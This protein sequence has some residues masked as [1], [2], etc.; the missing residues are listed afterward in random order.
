MSKQSRF[1]LVTAASIALTAGIAVS[2]TAA[3]SAVA[4]GVLRPVEALIVNTDSKPV[5][6]TVVGTRMHLGV[7]L[8]DHVMLAAS[9]VA[10]DCG[11]A[12]SFQ[13]LQP[14]GTVVDGPFIVPAGRSL[15]VLDVDAVI[16]AKNAGN[17]TN[18][19]TV[20]ATIMPPSQV[21]TGVFMFQMTNGVTITN[22]ITS[23]VAVSST[24]GAGVVFGA[25]QQV[26]IRGD[27]RGFGGGFL[28]ADVSNAMVR[29]YL[30]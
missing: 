21:P 16:V 19:R 4:Q 10:S 3:D 18:G 7:P 20:L 29:G 15:V 24:L 28:D 12:K 23:A 27:I 8:A 9:T 1:I 17:F 25:G 13:R 14:D 6:V 30:I 5:P 26:C 11:S 2:L 22:E